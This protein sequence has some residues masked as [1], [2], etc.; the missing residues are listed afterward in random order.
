MIH[1][2]ID[3]VS[4]FALPNVLE[5]KRTHLFYWVLHAVDESSSLVY[6]EKLRQYRKAMRLIPDAMEEGALEAVQQLYNRWAM[7]SAVEN[8]ELE[9]VKWLH[10]HRGENYSGVVDGVALAG[11]LEMLR[12]LHA[13]SN[14][15]NGHVHVMRFLDANYSLCW[16][17]SAINLAMKNERMEA[18]KWLHYHLKQ[19]L[20]PECV[21]DAA[22]NDHI[23]VLEFVRMNSNF[24]NN[25]EVYDMERFHSNPEV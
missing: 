22:R 19:P 2:F 16:P 1:A 3:T 5:E 21:V 20:S 24:A 17:H 13:N 18:V 10:N 14:A 11:H 8:N 23:A 12:W 4:R 7:K 9:I 15:E 6:H 25:P